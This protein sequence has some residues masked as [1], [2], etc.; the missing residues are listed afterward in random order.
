MV[1]PARR[2]GREASLADVCLRGHVDAH[3]EDARRGLWGEKTASC[4]CNAFKLQLE[5]RSA[6]A[7]MLLSWR[8]GTPVPAE[9]PGRLICATG[10]KDEGDLTAQGN[11]HLWDP[12][13]NRQSHSDH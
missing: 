5:I 13:P 7:S 6:P 10:E 1:R 3:R 9:S 12:A 2:K 11:L 8:G 4:M